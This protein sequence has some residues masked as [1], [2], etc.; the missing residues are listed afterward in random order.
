MTDKNFDSWNTTKKSL[1]EKIKRALNFHEREVWWCVLG[2][3]LGSE[4]DG[5]GPLF[6]RPALIL[7]K[8]SGS[9]AIVLPLSTKQK[10]AEFHI[11]VHCN[12]VDNFALL[13]QVRVIDSIR[14]KRKLG[15]ISKEEFLY[16]KKLFSSLV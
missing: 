7:R 1:Q 16:I 2:I 8:L 15:T 13:D 11:Q 14:F 12:E 9:T 3:N 5:A 10:R 6:E 4:Q